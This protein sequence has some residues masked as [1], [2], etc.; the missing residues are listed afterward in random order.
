MPTEIA[1]TPEG[2]LGPAEQSLCPSP[3]KKKKE[4]GATWIKASPL[5]SHNTAWRAVLQAFPF[6]TLG[7]EE[8]VSQSSSELRRG[9]QDITGKKV[10]KGQ[11]QKTW[12]W[13]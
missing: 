7:N 12:S 4:Q 6:Q 11:C 3:A 1:P 10:A 5:L 2:L 8:N 9:H 13:D